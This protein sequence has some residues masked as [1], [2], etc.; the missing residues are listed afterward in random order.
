[1][2]I[3]IIL[4]S[5]ASLPDSSQI[6]TPLY[7]AFRPRSRRRSKQEIQLPGF[8]PTAEAWESIQ[9]SPHVCYPESNASLRLYRTFWPLTQR[10]PIS[11]ATT[12]FEFM[13]ARLFSMNEGETQ[14]APFMGEKYLLEPKA[15]QGYSVAIPNPSVVCKPFVVLHCTLYA[16]LPTLRKA[17]LR[18]IARQQGKPFLMP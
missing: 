4:S 6:S 1:M 11:P 14:A 18:A 15:N 5:L 16:S 2:P 3:A 7:A 12:S 13:L 8:R 17:R 10:R 9:C